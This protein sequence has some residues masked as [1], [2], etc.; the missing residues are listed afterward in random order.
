L[1]T[2]NPDKEEIEVTFEPIQ[3]SSKS[4]QTFED[5]IDRLFG[6]GKI[7]SNFDLDN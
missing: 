3:S 4:K 7:N 6:G 1:Q 5:N 2:F